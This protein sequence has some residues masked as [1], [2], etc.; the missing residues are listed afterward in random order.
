MSKA[1]LLESNPD[2]IQE[3]IEWRANIRSGINLH[4]SS[5]NPAFDEI[6]EKHSDEQ[7]EILRN[8]HLDALDEIAAFRLIACIEARLFDDFDYRAKGPK[9]NP[10]AREFRRYYRNTNVTVKLEEHILPAWR[11]RGQPFKKL[12]DDFGRLLEFRH[13]VAHGKRWD[14]TM[15]DSSYAFVDVASLAKDIEEQFKL[16][17]EHW[18]NG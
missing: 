2:S 9:R 12:A 5:S 7:I 11:R 3:I 13:W 6:K 8:N 4:Y 1:N 16:L 17:P 18:P 14:A 10:L 15:I